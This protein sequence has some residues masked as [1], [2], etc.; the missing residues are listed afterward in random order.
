MAREHL[1]RMV[2]I[3]FVC[4]AF[5]ALQMAQPTQ[6]FERGVTAARP[7]A[8]FP[9]HKS[10]FP[11]QDKGSYL[12]CL[13]RIH[14]RP[15]FRSRSASFSHPI[16]MTCASA[17][18]FRAASVLIGS[19]LVGSSIDRIFPNTG[20][21]A[22]MAVAAICS[23]L[24]LVPSHHFLYDLCWTTFLPAS[25]AF[26]LLGRTHQPVHSG[27]DDDA[28]QSTQAVIK[29]VSIPFLIASIGSIIGC[30]ASFL[31]C[32]KFPSLWLQPKDAAVAASCLCASFIGGS[33]NFF[34]TANFI[35]GGGKASTLMSSMAAA[36]LLVMAVY[37][38]AMAGSLRSK[39]LTSLF[40]TGM[41]DNNNN[42]MR[43][44]SK[45]GA[46]QSTREEKRKAMGIAGSSLRKAQ[47]ATL[48][49]ALALIIV[50]ISTLFEKLTSAFLPG[51]TCASIAVLAPAVQRYLSSAKQNDLAKSMQQ[52]ASPLSDFC[53]QLLFASIGTSANLGEALV[54]GPACL[55]FSLLA[56]AIHILIVFSGSL[57]AKKIFH[58]PLVF[59]DVLVASNA[60]I[61][62]PAT[63]AAF[64]GRMK[65]PRQRGLT[66]AGTVWGVVGYAVGTTIGVSI[67]RI[68]LKMVTA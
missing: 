16:S 66:M 10:M 58:L 36:D 39:Y 67:F 21:L 17:A 11:C 7:A 41:S 31:V 51:T 12:G 44:D 3:S 57:H 61:G 55:L 64:A 26:L 40:G 20:I 2:L 37:F 30:I 54:Q 4:W 28:R 1:E 23:N 35:V 18:T 34:A 22:T 46:T 63:A 19:S 42:N 52:V 13:P 25:L 50:K 8:F 56:L 45:S 32:H 5:F 38:A 9:R 48:V 59:E 47:G 15:L 53:F 62:G 33:V 24:S 43:A 60:A 65:G 49:S 29:A 68:L 27:N 14:R 6:A